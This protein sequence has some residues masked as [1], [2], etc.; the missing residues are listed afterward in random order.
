MLGI[1]CSDAHTSLAVERGVP[2]W[3]RANLGWLACLERGDVLVSAGLGWLEFAGDSGCLPTVLGLWRAA[4]VRM[5]G[6]G[7]QFFTLLSLIISKYYEY[8]H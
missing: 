2:G 6:L 4:W 3:R 7:L 5:V 1:W 8:Y